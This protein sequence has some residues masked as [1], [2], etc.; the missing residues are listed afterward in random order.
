[1]ALYDLIAPDLQHPP[2][3]TAIFAQL[4]PGEPF[5]DGRVRYLKARLYTLLRQFIFLNLPEMLFEDVAVLRYLRENKLA[6][7]YRKE[8]NKLEAGLRENPA[9]DTVSYL[10]RYFLSFE[11]HNHHTKTNRVA[12]QYLEQLNLNLDLFFLVEKLKLACTAFNLKRLYNVQADTSLLEPLLLH[13]QAQQ[14]Y[15]QHPLL[16]IY[17]YAY[18]MLVSNDVVFYYQLKSNLLEQDRQYPADEIK[19]AYLLAMNFCIQEINKGNAGFYREAFLLY[20][21]GIQKHILLENGYLSPITYSNAITIALRGRDY[22][23]ALQFIETNKKIL[24]GSEQEGYY[25]FNLSKYYFETGNFE[26]VIELYYQSNIRELLLNIQVRVIQI[27]AFYEK[28]ELE[29]C[30]NLIDNL[31]QL[32]S[33]KGI[34]A[35]HKDNYDNFCKI[36][37]QLLAINNYDKNARPKLLA[38]AN[39]LSPLTEKNWLLEKYRNREA[40]VP[41]KKQRN[42]RLR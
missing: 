17:Y 8:Q 6:E 14:L 10:H 3:N 28:N 23:S 34:L 31:K 29:L 30:Q 9:A 39:N 36:F 12:T 42:S 11:W 7:L 26:K 2:G 13:I 19:D 25:F 20:E 27:K 33:R 5:N 40:C 16:G 38:H 35:Y 24:Q 21:Q 22:K 1:M 15:E 18:R 41:V 32:L 4:Y 37:K